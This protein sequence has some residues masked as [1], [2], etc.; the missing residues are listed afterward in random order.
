MIP[1]F[2]KANILQCMYMYTTFK[3]ICSFL[4]IFG[5]MLAS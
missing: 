2:V 4:K 3:V 1:T 5:E